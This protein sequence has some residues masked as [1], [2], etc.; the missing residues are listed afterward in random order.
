M[1]HSESNLIGTNVA[2]LPVGKQHN[3]AYETSGRIG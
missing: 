2:I 1:K 3:I